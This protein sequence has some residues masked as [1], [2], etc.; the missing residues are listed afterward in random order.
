MYTPADCIYVDDD[1]HAEDG[2]IG[3]GP[4]HSCP[5]PSNEVLETLTVMHRYESYTACFS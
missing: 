4:W 1:T 5:H 2:I 3:G